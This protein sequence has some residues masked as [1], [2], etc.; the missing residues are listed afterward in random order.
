MPTLSLQPVE[1]FISFSQEDKRSLS[2]LEKSL[3]VLERQRIIN[4][5]HGN[6]IEPGKDSAREISRLMENAHIILLL[7]SADFLNSEYSYSADLAHALERHAHGEAQLIPIILRP[8][9]WEGAEFRGLAALPEGA[10]PVSS[11]PTQDEAFANVAKSIRSLILDGVKIDAPKTTSHLKRRVPDLLLC[12]CNRIEQEESL[13]A[14]FSTENFD[15]HRPLVCFIH[16]GV[17]ECHEMYWSRL[18]LNSLPRLLGGGKFGEHS[19]HPIFLRFP[20]GVQSAEQGFSRLRS[21]LAEKVTRRRQASDEEIARSLSQIRAPIIIHSY[22][23][24]ANWEHHYPEIINAF[25]RY[26]SA[27]PDLPTTQLVICL[28][29][30]YRETAAAHSQTG[31]VLA[32]RRVDS[33]RRA[34]NYLNSLDLNGYVGVCGGVLPEMQAVLLEDAE[35]YF[36]DDEYFIELCKRHSPSFCNV[37]GAVEDIRSYYDG[38]GIEDADGVPMRDLANELRKILEKHLC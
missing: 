22:L 10:R 4:I 18:Q 37:P 9:D 13:S 28:F 35:N 33:A 24:A 21:T 17:N 36:R 11:W 20:R 32:G 2:R 19:V 25:I 26:W 38:F 1:V 14:I 29:V 30:I 27:F 7:V 31:A 6:R 3:A 34:R 12:L 16:G 15:Q 23:S 8:C 5:S